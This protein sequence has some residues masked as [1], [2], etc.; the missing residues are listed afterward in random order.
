[1]RASY[2]LAAALC[3]PSAAWAADPEFTNK[4]TLLLLDTLKIVEGT[5]TALPNG[6]YTVTRA[7][8]TKTYP[9][10]QVLFA[11]DTRAAVHDF[12]M[13]RAALDGPPKAA[14]AAG[15][16]GQG[17]NGLAL[18]AFPGK[19][20]PV[21]TNLCANCHAKADYPG[22]F[23]L[24]PAPNGYA[25]PGAAEAN[26]KATLT[27]VSRTDPSGSPLLEKMLAK[28]GN[29]REPAVHLA[30]HPAYKN[31][32]LWV[33]WV[34]MPDGR[35]APLSLPPRPAKAVTAGANRG[36]PAAEISV[37]DPAAFNRAMHPAKK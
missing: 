35:R 21:L 34:A 26:L 1:M 32:E 12:L 8:E 7:G 13:A 30:T 28:H 5:V 20:Q 33:H 4:P 37:H 11:G 6:D 17:Y 18:K 15:V 16:S 14:P 22:P 10:K 24:T 3:L 23:K 29:Q 25:D 27:A 2:L 31:L 36:T 19:V 9:A